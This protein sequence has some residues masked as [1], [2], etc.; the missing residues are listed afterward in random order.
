MTPCLSTVA[1]AHCFAASPSA[2]NQDLWQR[3]LI[4]PVPL[5]SICKS[6]PRLCRGGLAVSAQSIAK[7]AAASLPHRTCLSLPCEFY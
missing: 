3:R 1:P 4:F 6:R 2:R 5:C 7:G